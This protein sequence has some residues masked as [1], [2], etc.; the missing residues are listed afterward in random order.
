LRS[1]AAVCYRRRVNVAVPRAADRAR[2][3]QDVIRACFKSCAKA[4]RPCLVNP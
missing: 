2:E 3:L 4:Q 1:R